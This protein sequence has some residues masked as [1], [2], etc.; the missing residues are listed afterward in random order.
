M[1][2]KFITFSISLFL[3][4]T[5]SK[6][7]VGSDESSFKTHHKNVYVELLGSSI[8]TGINFDMRLNPGKMDG[9]GFRAGVGGLNIKGE[10]NGEQY[11]IGLVTFPLEFNHLVGEGKHSFVSGVGLLPAYATIS[12][13]GDFSEDTWVQADGFGL[14]GGFLTLGYRRQP[15]N[16]GFMFQANLNPLVLRGSGFKVGWI[17]IGIGFGFK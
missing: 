2:Q 1:K 6:A 11:E 14:A 8:L 16:N 13:K 12:G 5:I 15:L 3:L 10:T 4:F 17:G 9:T 7:Q